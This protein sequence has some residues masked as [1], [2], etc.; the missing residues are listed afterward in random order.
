[1]IPDNENDGQNEKLIIEKRTKT[2]RW[3]RWGGRGAG[4]GVS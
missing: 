2:N 3:R 1:M 4:G